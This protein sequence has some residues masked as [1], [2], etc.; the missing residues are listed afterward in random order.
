MRCGDLLRLPSAGG[1]EFEQKR[2]VG[3][4][5][6]D[7]SGEKSLILRRTPQVGHIE[8]GQG[9]KTRQA[10]RFGDEEAQGGDGRGL[11]AFAAVMG[12]RFQGQKAFLKVNRIKLGANFLFVNLCRIVLVR[13]AP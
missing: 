3:G 4:D 10:L 13:S 6:G 5:I 11:C 8:T 2:F 7:N 12:E 1:G 9:D